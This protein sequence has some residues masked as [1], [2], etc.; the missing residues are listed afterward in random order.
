MDELTIVYRHE[1][2]MARIV[3]PAVISACVLYESAHACQAFLHIVKFDYFYRFFYA[4][5]R[6]IVST[7][8]INI[9]L[10]GLFLK[11]FEP[12]VIFFTFDALNEDLVL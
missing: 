3:Q 9:L 12:V 2:T 5:I 8:A 7:V 6:T 11:L 4:L 10:I 1:L